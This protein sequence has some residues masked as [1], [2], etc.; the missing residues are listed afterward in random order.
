M[1]WLQR[2]E[3]IFYGVRFFVLRCLFHFIQQGGNAM[4]G[5]IFAQ[6]RLGALFI[7]SMLL[8]SA[9]AQAAA[10]T[11][12]PTAVQIVPT[13]TSTAASIGMEGAPYCP[14]VPGQSEAL[15]ITEEMFHTPTPAPLPTS[16]PFQSTAVDADTTAQQIA[17]YT[18]I[19]SLVNDRYVYRDF[20]GLDWLATGKHY[21]TI[22]RQGLSMEDFYRAMEEMIN[23]L[24]DHHSHF[25]SPDRVQEED[26][27]RMG[28]TDFVGIGAMMNV[29]QENGQPAIF[30]VSILPGS[31][32]EKAGLKPHDTI[33]QVDGGPVL[34]D[35]G[36]PRTLGPENTEVVIGVHSPAQPPRTLRLVRQRIRADLGIE[37]CL[38]RNTH[39]G[40]LGV[41]S[42]MDINTPALIRSAINKMSAE[43]PLEGLILDN[44][45]NTGGY[46][47][48]EKAILALF[49]SGEQGKA[50]GIDGQNVWYI[51]PLDIDGSQSVPM[52][53]LVDEISASGGEIV[54]GMLQN[55]QR[56]MVVGRQ[57]SGLTDGL[58]VISLEDGSQLYLATMSF[59][60]AGG[61]IGQWEKTGITPDVVIPAS[62]NQYNEANDPI[63]A[64]AVELLLEK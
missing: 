61:E 63:M 33:I 11:A 39:I 18:Q 48:T 31:P 21:E 2:S 8:A 22:I 7:L 23:Q 3:S 57:T 20:H 27:L 24:G 36:D 10:P 50:V 49:T 40:Y 30:L 45:N 44:R 29:S 13:P 16:I 46:F 51:T 5:S 6:R 41:R 58:D 25:Y 42:Y 35:S 32:A 19:W 43:A 47:D 55:S 62:W 64:K 1:T 60:P 52:V 9:C 59:Q 4:S 14:Y 15:Q 28:K 56:A 12:T 17:L 54:P 26:Q 37:F 53:V 34:D 38:V